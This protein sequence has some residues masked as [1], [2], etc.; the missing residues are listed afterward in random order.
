MCVVCLGFAT[1]STPL[2]ASLCYV[3]SGVCSQHERSHVTR[4]ALNGEE[5]KERYG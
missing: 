2:V 5:S 3:N 1:Q 4:A